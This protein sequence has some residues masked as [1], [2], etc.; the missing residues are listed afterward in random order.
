MRSKLLTKY[1]KHKKEETCTRIVHLGGS[2]TRNDGFFPISDGFP[3]KSRCPILPQVL[4]F[5]PGQRCPWAPPNP[6][7]KGVSI[8]GWDPI[9]G[10]FRGWFNHEKWWLISWKIHENRM[11]IWGYHFRKPRT[12]KKPCRQFNTDRLY[13]HNF[14]ELK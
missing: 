4:R 6:L 8:H 10:W 7:Q 3:P 5:G 13:E 2:I 9:A 11:M 14:P 12:H 1:L